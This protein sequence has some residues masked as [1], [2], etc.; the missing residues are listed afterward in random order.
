MEP[1]RDNVLGGRPM[2]IA[3]R[4]GEVLLP[5]VT[6]FDSS[7][8]VDFAALDRLLAWLLDRGMC[9]SLFIGGTTG[10]F[11]ALSLEE[12]VAIFE[13][14]RTFAGASVPLIAG[15]GAATTRDA[16]FLTREAERL[17]YDAAAVILPYYSRPTQ[18]EIYQHFVA[19][20]RATALPVILYNIPLFT[21]VNLMPETLARLADLPNVAG[22]KDQAGANPVQASDYLRVAPHLAVYCGDD[23]MILQVLAQGGVG[24]VSGGAHVL[25]RLIKEMIRKFK[26][27]D[28][29]GATAIHHR[30]MPF[31]RALTPG[32]RAN[33]I[34]LTRM[35]VTLVTGVDVGPPR[36]PLMLPEESEVARLRGVLEGLGLLTV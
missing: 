30:L 32:G 24:C 14:V 9:D 7:G 12:R 23:A 29:D 34:P 13:R 33:P 36:P 31:H 19:V 22:V 21:G 11:H 6:P 26:A 18:D 35:A 20:A 28:V 4:L 17:G 10:E 25:G 8:A 2:T 27:G 15:T 16:V 3:A 5:P 1:G